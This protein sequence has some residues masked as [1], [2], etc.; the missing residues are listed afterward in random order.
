LWNI[1]G[2]LPRGQEVAFNKLSKNFGQDGRE[3]KNEVKVVA[4]L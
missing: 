3:F 4:K 2:L 1:Q